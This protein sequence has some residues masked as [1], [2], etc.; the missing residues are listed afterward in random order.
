[1]LDQIKRRIPEPV[2]ERIRLLFTPTSR[3]RLSTD[4]DP[5]RQNIYVFLCG[6]YQNLGDMAL[7][8]A[9][10]RFLRHEFPGANIILIPSVDT[11]AATKYIKKRIRPH[12]LVT[13]L[14][15]G[16]MGDM[17]ISLENARLHVVKSLKKNHIVC[18]PQTYVFSNTKT[19]KQRE[20]ISRKVYGSHPN[21]DIFVREPFSLERIRHALPRNRIGCC[22]DTVLSLPPRNARHERKN[23]LIC[24]RKDQEQ[25]TESA[26]RAKL[27]GALEKE[28]GS[29]IARD[30][31]D[32]RLEECTPQT[33]ADTLERFWDLLGACK[34]A[35]TD[36]LHCV[37]F[38]VLTRT[39]CVAIDNAN[40][41]ISGVYQA[42]LRKIPYIRFLE[43]QDADAVIATARELCAAD[44][45]GFVYDF[46]EEFSPLKRALH[47]P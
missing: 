30:T 45:S 1:M 34:V 42:W 41:K 36:R 9:Q 16:N 22:P 24:L 3:I 20:A 46:S 33:Y 38:C 26:F 18:F 15:G 11:Y 7:T 39:P 6:F 17:Y 32:V 29:I 21:I 40:H 31:V 28:V 27:I 19:G 12:D 43:G 5:D 13:V 23:V 14:G 4:I 35:I 2:K 47:K 8:Y 44:Y 37:I 10:E 25:R